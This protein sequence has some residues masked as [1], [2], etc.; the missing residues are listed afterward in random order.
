MVAPMGLLFFA[1][2]CFGCAGIAQQASVTLAA[3][4]AETC[5]LRDANQGDVQEL[6]KGWAPR[7]IR[8]QQ[9]SCTRNEDW[10]EVTLVTNFVS[11]F[12]FVQ[13]EVTWHAT[14]ENY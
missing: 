11:P 12:T 8:V 9:V 13:S 7:F 14:S 5:G 10:A 6:I 2:L 4:A 3:R 1:L